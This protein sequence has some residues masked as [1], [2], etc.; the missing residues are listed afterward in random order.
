MH[1]KG[2]LD[3]YNELWKLLD[4]DVTNDFLKKFIPL[5]KRFVRPEKTLIFESEE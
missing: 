4:N 3:A 2:I 5:F 1:T